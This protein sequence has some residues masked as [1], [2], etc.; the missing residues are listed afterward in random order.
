[1]GELTPLRVER[2]FAALPH[3]AGPNPNVVMW[4]LDAPGALVQCIEPLKGTVEDSSWLVST[5]FATLDSYF[6]K[7]DDLVLVLDLHM[8]LGRTA[9]ARSILL[10]SFR[11]L[12]KRFAN[13]YVVPPAAYPPIYRQAFQASLAF[14][15]LLGIRVTLA[16]SS[17]QLIDRYNLRPLG[18]AADRVLAVTV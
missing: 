15:R 10:N 2:A 16:A 7:R 3:V 9:A 17:A 5:A 12:G 4:L 13:V 18:A 1:M 6:P 14:A 11:L 8:L